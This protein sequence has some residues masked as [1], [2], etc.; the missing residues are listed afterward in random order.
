MKKLFY[1]LLFSALS[2]QT[3]ASFCGSTGVPFSFENCS[4][5]FSDLSCLRKDQWV[6]GI[7][8]IDH[9]RQPLILQCCTFPGL[10]FSQEVGITNVGPGEAITGGEVIRD[11]RQISFDVIANARKV[12]DANTHIVS[13][14]VTVRRM[15]CLPDP[16]EPVVDC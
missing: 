4:G 1:L 14:E 12:V 13:Y 5:Q 7:E 3:F 6:G 8:Y 10:R 11:G 15:H 9:P 2:Y 16:P